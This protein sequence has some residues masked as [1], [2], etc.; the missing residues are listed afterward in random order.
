MRI[1]D[2]ENRRTGKLIRRFFYLLREKSMTLPKEKTGKS[3]SEGLPNV[4]TVLCG[5]V[6]F[7]LDI[8]S[9]ILQP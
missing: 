2:D 7:T 9:D 3:A 4:L 5:I 6:F 8:K 1:S